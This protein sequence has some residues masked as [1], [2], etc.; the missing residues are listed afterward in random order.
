MSLQSA[1]NS[2]LQFTNFRYKWRELYSQTIKKT[3][4]NDIL[5]TSGAQRKQISTY[6]KCFSPFPFMLKDN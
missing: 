4:N 2:S 5:D 3:G 6:L 1:G